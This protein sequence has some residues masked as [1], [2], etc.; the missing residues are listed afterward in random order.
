MKECYFKNFFALI[1]LIFVFLSITIKA[2]TNVSGLIST[3]TT[4]SFAGSP[5]IVTGNV[6][7]DQTAELSIEPGVTVKFNAGTSIHIDGALLAIGTDVSKIIFT[8]NASTPQPGDWGYLYFSDLSTDAEFD[9]SD[10]YLSGSILKHVIVEYG[11]GA[12]VDNN[13]TIRLENAHPFID[14]S[15][16]INN[17]MTGITGWLLSGDLRIT[18]NVIENNGTIYY[19]SG[20]IYLDDWWQGANVRIENN[21]IK[22][23][24]G[25]LC[26]G[27][28]A[29][30]FKSAI[31]R[32]N[33][34]EDN[35]SESNGGGI[36]FYGTGLLEDNIIYNNVSKGPGAGIFLLWSNA[37]IT[38]NYIINNKA[39]GINV[40]GGGLFI[41][42]TDNGVIEVSNNIFAENVSDEEGGGVYVLPG[43]SPGTTIIYQHNSFIRNTAPLSA[44]GRFSESDKDFKYNTITENISNGST[45]TGAV[46]ISY[47]PLFNYNNIFNNATEYALWNDNPQTSPNVDGTNN[48]WGSSV[49]N[50]VSAAVY[51]WFDESALGIFIHSPYS[52]NFITTAPVSSPVNFNSVA[53]TDKIDVSW[54]ANFEPDIAGY[55]IYWGLVS[56]LP[57]L[58]S[59]DVG[60]VTNYSIEG[61]SG[62]SY[63]VTLTAYDNDAASITD[64]LIT[65]VNEKQISGNE[66]W[67]A[68]AVVSDIVSDVS[69]DKSIYPDEF[70]LSQNYPNPFNPGTVISYKLPASGN[71][72]LKVY[73][74]LGNE[75]A[76]LVNEEKTAGSYVV[77]FNASELSTGV[78]FYRLQAGSFVQTKKMTVIK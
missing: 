11:G 75:I 77:D 2:Q 38:K 43:Y 25:G 62:G 39:Q 50:E 12:Q 54:S 40:W 6:L 44:A 46:K 14:N 37:L 78:Y 63:F 20:G 51:D 76:A 26:G 61:L 72:T 1:V 4:W 45:P 18:N 74:I 70:E 64:N 21:T 53:G 10:N 65:I 36:Y 5:Y 27:I 66:S 56:Q 47:T 68:K 41:E 17:Y 55:K 30:I 33:L 49:E 42:P 35:S 69:E 31:I 23:N 28:Y 59:E 22:N 24:I 8:S 52:S 16:I 29:S 7:V 67:Y 60:N 34:I 48:W 71:V 58:N 19:N 9:L 73:D 57:Y 32:N 15:R 13:G 3:N